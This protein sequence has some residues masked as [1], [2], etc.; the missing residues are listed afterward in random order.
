MKLGTSAVDHVNV[1][2]F[3]IPKRQNLQPDIS[4]E[5]GNDY[6]T[7]VDA[8]AARNQVLR[9]PLQ[10]ER[11]PVEHPQSPVVNPGLAAAV[12][13]HDLE[14]GDAIDVSHGDGTEPAGVH[15]LHPFQRTRC[16]IVYPRVNI[17]KV[18]DAGV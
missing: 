16:R 13:D 15:A 10:G 1:G 3:A 11:S 4:V 14:S 6:C 17:G 12:T 8:G 18:R 9:L 2:R 7:V 5:L